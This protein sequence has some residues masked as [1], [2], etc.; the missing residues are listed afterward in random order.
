MTDDEMRVDVCAPE[1]PGTAGESGTSAN[2]MQ[3]QLNEGGEAAMVALVERPRPIP[4]RCLKPGA[5]SRR[6]KR[7][8]PP[9]AGGGTM[10]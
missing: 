1:A 6:C 8:V 2:D 9:S 5:R 10:P 3:P 7:P 4:A